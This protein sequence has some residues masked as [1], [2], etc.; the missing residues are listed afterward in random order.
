MLA[1]GAVACEIVIVISQSD[2]DISMTL[3]VPNG[4]NARVCLPPAHALSPSDAAKT[5]LHLDGK[6]I[7]SDT[8]GRMLC[9]LQDLE[10]GSYVLSRSY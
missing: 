3:T 4:T 7:H 10:P 9:G 5:K 8:Y 2:T 6:V 1:N